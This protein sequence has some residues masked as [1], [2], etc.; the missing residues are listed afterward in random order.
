MV[1]LKLL[2]DWIISF[3]KATSLFYVYLYTIKL[4]IC[5]IE[6]NFDHKTF[7]LWNDIE[8]CI[9]IVNSMSVYI[10]SQL[11]HTEWRLIYDVYLFNS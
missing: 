10:I 3:T 1:K 6:D 11:V 2:S 5:M 9:L 4:L 7:A 8:I